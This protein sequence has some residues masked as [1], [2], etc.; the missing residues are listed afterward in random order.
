VSAQIRLRIVVLLVIL[1]EIETQKVLLHSRSG[2]CLSLNQLDNV[3]DIDNRAEYH[4]RELEARFQES[5]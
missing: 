2:K 3:C 5:L 1:E 4:L